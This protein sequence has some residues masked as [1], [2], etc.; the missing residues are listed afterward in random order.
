MVTAT[1]T[2]AAVAAVAAP[3]A[4]VALPGDLEHI[5]MLPQQ[6]RVV[7]TTIIGCGE[8]PYFMRRVLFWHVSLVET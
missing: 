4:P 1:S 2:L 7:A 3:V 8:K 5:V 6:L